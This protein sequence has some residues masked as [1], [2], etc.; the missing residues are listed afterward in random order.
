MMNTSQKL[1]A[2]LS[3]AALL[4]VSSLA[5]QTAT[6][7]PVGYVT[8][9]V[10]AHGGTGATLSLHS[11]PLKEAK[12]I[13]GVTTD[14][15]GTDLTVAGADF[16]VEAGLPD[17]ASVDA[18]N[19][20]LY[21]VEVSDGALVG[22]RVDI[23]GVVGPT[24]TLAEDVDLLDDVTA[25]SI[26]KYWTLEDIFG[27]I[28]EDSDL[29]ASGDIGDVDL[30][31]VSDNA[32]GFDQYYLY[33]APVFLGGAINWAKVGQATSSVKATSRIPDD[34]LLIQRVGATVRAASTFTNMGEVKVGAAK[35]PVF[36]GV[37]LVSFSYPVGTTLGASGLETS[38]LTPNGDVALA[39]KV[40]VTS[41][42][43]F[44]QFYLYQAPV[45]LGGAISWAEVGQPSTSDK[46]TVTLDGPALILRIDATSINWAQTQPYTL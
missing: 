30:I 44:R 2:L 7:A 32:G 42:G 43:V 40:L 31:L 33:Q 22:L 37:N 4:S 26:K 9:D 19:S 38:G 11:L 28:G 34:T 20:P 36:Q 3:G 17:F 25:F 16:G 5:A 15:T 46:A 1:I 6:T 27:T 35:A 41:G 8:E 10:P 29:K 21:Y 24:L 39:D 23:T 18:N 12:A 14:V 45:F 13:S